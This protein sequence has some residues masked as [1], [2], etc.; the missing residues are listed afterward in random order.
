VTAPETVLVTG[1]SGFAGSHLV[2]R[3]AP[4]RDIV[5]WGRASR[6]PDRAG[7]ARWHRIDLLDRDAVRAA[8]RELQPGVVFHCAGVS[9]VDRSWQAPAQAL[10]G[11]V[12]A[13]HHLLD[14]LRRTGRLCRVLI[15]GSAAVYAASPSPLTEESPVA[16]DSPYA[17][18]KLAQER[19]GVR[20]VAEDGLEVVVTRSFNHTGP[21]QSPAFMASGVAR[22]IALI[23]RGAL[24]PVIRVGNLEARRDLTDVRDVVRAYAALIEAGRPGEVYN[25]ASGLGRTVAEVITALVALAGVDVR[26]E[27]DPS[28]LRPLDNPVLVGDASRLRALTNWTPEISFEQMLQELLEYWRREV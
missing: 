18:S 9:Q 10:A 7:G 16:P 23:E 21:G 6:L 27:V 14:A 4:S 13:T 19:L 28:R 20:A 15:T 11:N 8:V 22:Q 12:L 3:L 2:Q 26:V 5:G 24:E 25:V 17:L 1:A